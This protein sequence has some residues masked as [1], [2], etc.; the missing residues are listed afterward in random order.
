MPAGSR[1]PLTPIRNVAPTRTKTLGPNPRKRRTRDR[2]Q[3]DHQRDAQPSRAMS[4]EPATAALAMSSTGRR[5]AA[6]RLLVEV[7][8]VVDVGDQGGH[9]SN[10]RRRSIPPAHESIA[11]RPAGSLIDAPHTEGV[12]SLII[13]AATALNDPTR[14]IIPFPSRP[15][16]RRR[17][18]RG[19]KSSCGRRGRPGQ[20]AHHRPTCAVWA[21]RR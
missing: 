1:P 9:R 20:P 3:P 16:A 19:G 6:H 13:G 2:A 5:P 17:P 21:S 11:T 4:I 8:G 15:T 14:A 12:P 10:V 18:A 7:Q